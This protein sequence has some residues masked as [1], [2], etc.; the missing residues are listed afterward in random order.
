MQWKQEQ[1]FNQLLQM[2][3]KTFNILKKSN[4]VQQEEFVDRNTFWGPDGFHLKSNSLM[5]TSKE[6]FRM[7]HGSIWLLCIQNRYG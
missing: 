6:I 4:I 5:L 1:G 3:I 7:S 2:Q